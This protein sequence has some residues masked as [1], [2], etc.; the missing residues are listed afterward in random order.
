MKACSQYILF[1][2]QFNSFL[3]K[4]LYLLTLENIFDASVFLETLS[5]MILYPWLTNGC[6]ELWF[7]IYLTELLGD[8]ANNILMVLLS[9][10]LHRLPKLTLIS[11][12]LTL[13]LKFGLS[14]IYYPTCP[15]LICGNVSFVPQCL[16]TLSCVNST[17][18]SLLNLNSLKL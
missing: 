10:E 8:S 1:C 13:E 18:C 15:R 2:Q 17:H 16:H 7:C 9:L 4:L 3:L 11:G 5:S 14:W 12:K 6:F